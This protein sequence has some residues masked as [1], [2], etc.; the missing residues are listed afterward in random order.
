MEIIISMAVIGILMAVSAPLIT[1]FSTLKTGI[2][3][4]VMKCIIN[5]DSSGWYDT[6]GAG[7]TILP[8]TDPCRTAVIDVQHDKNK[9]LNA[10]IRIAKNGTSSQKIMIKRIF[11]AACDQ[12]GT[13]ACDYFINECRINGLTVSPFCDD[14]TDYTDLTYY[15]H[16]N[17]NIYSNRG[18]AYI[19]SQL[20]KLLPKMSQNL[21]SQVLDAKTTA[22]NANDNIATD[23]A[24][25]SAYIQ[26]CNAG[27]QDACDYAYNN[28]YNKSCYQI[29]SNWELAP[30]KTYNLTY[31]DAGTIRTESVSCDTTSLPSAAITGCNAITAN[32]LTNAPYDD[33]TYAYNNNYNRSCSRIPANWSSA[34]TATYNLTQNGAPPAAL[35][36]TQCPPPCVVSGVGSVCV[37]NSVY[38]G[39]LNGYYYYAPPVDQSNGIAWAVGPTAPFTGTT[40]TTDGQTNTATLLGLTDIDAPYKAAGACKTLNDASTYGYNDWYL[41]AS[42]EIVPLYTN[43]VAIGNFNNAGY[44]WTSREHSTNQNLAYG[45]TFVSNYAFETQKWN[46]Y[47]VRCVRKKLALDGT[48]PTPGNTCADGTKYA[49]PYST[50]YLFVTPMDQGSYTWS[51]GLAAAW[52]WTYASDYDNGLANSTKILALADTNAPYNAVLACKTLNDTSEY[53]HNDWYLPARTELSLINT[54][55]YLIGGL[56]TSGGYYWSSTENTNL[57]AYV[58]IMGSGEGGYMKIN[59]YRVRCVRKD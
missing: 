24:Q 1:Q 57:N 48:C 34:P 35:V 25:P 12:G 58:R 46:S 40:S 51:N 18:A 54:N 21:L 42:A 14:T 55:K 39:T 47:Y 49:G 16:L 11:R 23:L 56:T 6:D 3:K 28:N 31:D 50:Y 7:A 22:P 27:I 2:N 44:Y 43:R 45:Y 19:S 41:P 13:G 9:S 4:N 30:T 33:C 38:A 10:A 52:L 15:L 53:S 29:I 5:D 20:T 37:G 59:G 17:R 32:L 26:G 8:T 36:S